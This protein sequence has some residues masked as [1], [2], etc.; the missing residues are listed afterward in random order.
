MGAIACY[1]SSNFIFSIFVDWLNDLLIREKA[2]PAQTISAHLILYLY[3]VLG[4]A[5]QISA[6]LEQ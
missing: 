6:S 1:G 4:L 5:A 3:S 2:N